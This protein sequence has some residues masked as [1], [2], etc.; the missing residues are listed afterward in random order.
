MI[1]SG[2]VGDGLL[3]LCDGVSIRLV[4]VH[5]EAG[6]GLCEVS[7]FGRGLV[8]FSVNISLYKGRVSCRLW[9]PFISVAVNQLRKSVSRVCQRKLV[10]FRISRERV[11]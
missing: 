1:M 2:K 9:P 5:Q 6:P 4:A 3:Y 11:F 10:H 7:V 8:G